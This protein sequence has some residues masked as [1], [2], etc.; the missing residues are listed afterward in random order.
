MFNY[1]LLALLDISFSAVQPLFLA[2]L[3]S[4][5]GLGLGP[6]KIGSIL[7][8]LGFANGVMQVFCF[9]RAVKA[10]GARNV[11]TIGI[12]CYAFI[13]SAYPVMYS[14]ASRAPAG[15]MPWSVWVALGTQ[16]SLCIMANMAWGS[17]SIFVVSSAPSRQAMGATNGLNQTLS[18][19]MRAIGPAGATSLFALTVERNLL[20]GFLIYAVF[21]V[22]TAMAVSASALLPKNAKRRGE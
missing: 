7:G 6:A 22:I 9:P 17:I 20:N 5:G 19:L 2:A 12:S 18:S 13:F 10:L 14:L 4:A 1:A 16:L 8:T 11:Y 3:H 15:E 21:V